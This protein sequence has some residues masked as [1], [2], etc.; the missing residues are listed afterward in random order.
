MDSQDRGFFDREAGELVDEEMMPSSKN[1]CH[2]DTVSDGG[3][4]QH[5]DQTF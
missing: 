1:P 3:E 2:F 5:Y 4:N